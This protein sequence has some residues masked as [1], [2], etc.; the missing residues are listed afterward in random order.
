MACAGQMSTRQERAIA[1]NRQESIGCTPGELIDITAVIDVG[2]TADGTI[3]S[4][5]VDTDICRIGQA[6]LYYQLQPP[7]DGSFELVEF[8]PEGGEQA[9]TGEVGTDVTFVGEIRSGQTADSRPVWGGSTGGRNLCASSVLTPDSRLY[10]N[11]D[12]LRVGHL[13]EFSEK[14]PLRIGIGVRGG[15]DVEGMSVL[16]T[17]A[18]AMPKKNQA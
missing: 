10:V 8:V 2:A 4:V 6:G 15:Q 1:A 9:T 13:R 3:P 17:V 5:L 11:T 14:Q 18:C 7:G 16:V 12:P